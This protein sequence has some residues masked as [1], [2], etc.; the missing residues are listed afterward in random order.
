MRHENVDEH[1]QD[2]ELPHPPLLRFFQPGMPPLPPH[3]RKLLAV[4]S[5][6]AHLIEPLLRRG[7]ARL[8]DASRVL[9]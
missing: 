8:R 3:Q 1:T 4:Q 5:Q 6:A 9:V 7:G 2:V